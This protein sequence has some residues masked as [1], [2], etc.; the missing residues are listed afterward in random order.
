MTASTRNDLSLFTDNA[1]SLPDLAAPLLNDPIQPVEATVPDVNKLDGMIKEFMES[2]EKK[3]KDNV[4]TKMLA[5]QIILAFV[6]AFAGFLYFDPAKE[7]AAGA[8]DDEWLAQA[9]PPALVRQYLYFLSGFIGFGS[10]NCTFSYYGPQE[11]IAML[12]R[13]N[14]RLSKVLATGG[15]V[16]F[17]LLQGLQIYL[18]AE[19][20]GSTFANMT[21]TVTGSLPGAINGAV[22]LV[23][24]LP[25][26]TASI[27]ETVKKVYYNCR[28]KHLSAEKRHEMAIEAFYAWERKKFNKLIDANWK[29][30]VANVHT[31]EITGEENPLEFL[32]AQ[33]ALPEVESWAVYGMR[34]LIQIGVG[35]SL[36]AAFSAPML[37]N[38]YSIMREQIDS[39]VAAA[40]V[41]TA[42][43]ATTLY[44]NVSLT[45]KAMTAATSAMVSKLQ[46]EPINSL[47]YQLRPWQTRA[48]VSASVVLA[49]LSYAVVDSMFQSFWAPSVAGHWNGDAQSIGR[50][51]A[52]TGIDLYHVM[53]PSDVG[54]QMLFLRILSKGTPKEKF[55]ARLLLIVDYLTHK[56]SQSTFIQEVG[57]ELSAAARMQLGVRSWDD[58]IASIKNAGGCDDAMRLH[59]KAMGLNEFVDDILALALTQPVAE[60]SVSIDAEKSSESP[61]SKTES[62]SSTAKHWESTN[63]ILSPR[64][65][66][67]TRLRSDSMTDRDASELR[68]S[69]SPMP[70][71]N[72]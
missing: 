39:P 70:Q 28:V 3:G 49:A 58:F 62:V 38:T 37:N 16:G 8:C 47:V 14:G 55:L 25:K 32:L 13:L 17:T 51:M 30:V 34:K 48:M 59:M 6:G 7:C 52:R 23:S 46:G 43:C 21:M 19:G 66:N 40:I 12:D 4:S 33:G 56:M 65:S 20:T 60:V 54:T 72:G 50:G 53:G 35:G 18:S 5:A 67:A 27:T 9:I 10:T 64:S 44:G 71:W 2:L 42:F 36:T 26:I 69:P 61:Q 29:S 22:G 45:N 63:Y 15:V 57:G 68:Q 24:S 1:S 41:S 11:Y 31:L